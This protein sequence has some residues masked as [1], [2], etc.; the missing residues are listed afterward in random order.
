MN[1]HYLH[2]FKINP[3]FLIVQASLKNCVRIYDICLKM[4]KI[5]LP[6]AQKPLNEAR[7]QLLKRSLNSQFLNWPWQ[8]ILGHFL[9]IHRTCPSSHVDIVK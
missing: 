9:Q 7:F 2:L 3:R 5:A 6:M 1:L 4:I 8:F